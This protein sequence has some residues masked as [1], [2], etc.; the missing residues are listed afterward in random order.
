MAYL[1][2]TTKTAIDCEVSRALNELFFATS[3]C[4][5]LTVATARFLEVG[6]RAPEPLYYMSCLG[7]TRRLYL[8]LLHKVSSVAAV[9]DTA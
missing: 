3:R 6:L 5:R 9:L 8:Y 7:R 4:R 2:R 1:A